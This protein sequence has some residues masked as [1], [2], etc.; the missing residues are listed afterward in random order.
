MTLDI[1]IS[2]I[3]IGL[4]SSL[5]LFAIDEKSPRWLRKHSYL[6]TRT[7]VAFWGMTLML[8]GLY[9]HQKTARLNFFFAALSFVLGVQISLWAIGVSL[10]ILGNVPNAIGHLTATTFRHQTSDKSR[11]IEENPENRQMS[12]VM[13]T[14]VN[15]GDTVKFIKKIYHPL[16]FLLAL[17]LG[18][19]IGHKIKTWVDLGPQDPSHPET[20]LHTEPWMLITS[21]TIMVL[22]MLKDRW[23]E[24]KAIRTLEDLNTASHQH[25]ADLTGW[26]TKQLTPTIIS[27]NDSDK[28]LKEASNIIN[29]AI[30]EPS[31]A[32]KYVVFT[33]SAA[34][35]KD[36]PNEESDAE[37]ALASYRT[38][39]ARL[40]SET[41]PVVRYI[42]LLEPSDYKRR[43][44]QTR[45][46]YIK[47]LEK[48]ISLIERNPQYLLFDCPRAPSWG[49]SRSSIFTARALLDIVGNGQ[50]GILIRG[51][52]VAQDLKNSSKELFEQAAV[53][54]VVHN[55][56]TLLKYMK[57]L[58]D[59]EV[60]GSHQDDKSAPSN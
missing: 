35:Y 29:V 8:L 20:L 18:A 44:E 31:D 59:S 56:P 3:V 13:V 49:S 40:G 55:K 36:P 2:A 47:W 27:L 4:L 10:Q 23:F 5:F 48:Q 11:L 46:A 33:G 51:D 21:I 24:T 50:T 39:M 19:L 42:S 15:K 16:Y 57:S 38:A 37:T 28:V 54:P 22:V 53:Q 34:L 7:V 45:D 41:I 52:Q 32:E 26:I 60:V 9:F 17:F 14:P 30:K 25:Y 12:V 43:G 1:P 6:L 58:K